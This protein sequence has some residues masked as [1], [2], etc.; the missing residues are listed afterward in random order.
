MSHVITASTQTSG[1]NQKARCV[2]LR[3]AQRREMRR[4]GRSITSAA[5]SATKVNLKPHQRRRWQREV[6]FLKNGERENDESV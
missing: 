1:P 2:G 4:S 6:K 5:I 3:D